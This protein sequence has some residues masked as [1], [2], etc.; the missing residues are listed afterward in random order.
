MM[1]PQSVKALGLFLSVFTV[2][3]LAVTSLSTVEAHPH[4]CVWKL[5]YG[6]VRGSVFLRVVA[7][8]VD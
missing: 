3:M 5:E 8:R 7:D 2:W 4:R 1:I 6:P